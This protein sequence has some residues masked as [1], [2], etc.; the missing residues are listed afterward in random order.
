MK[1]IYVISLLAVAGIA[2][3]FYK[4]EQVVSLATPAGQQGIINGVGQLQLRPIPDAATF[5]A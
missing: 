3:V 5:W 4:K 1:G 2:Y